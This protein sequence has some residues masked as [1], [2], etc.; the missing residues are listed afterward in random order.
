MADITMR[1]QNECPNAP[2]CYR[3]QAV[4]SHWQSVGAFPFAVVDGEVH[5]DFY[6]PITDTHSREAD[7]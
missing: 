4:P 5:C 1:A 7:L 2:T 6:I 3:K